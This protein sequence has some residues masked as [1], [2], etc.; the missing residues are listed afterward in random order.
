MNALHMGEQIII[1]II[2]VVTIHSTHSYSI[3]H[4]FVLMSTNMTLLIMKYIDL[5]LNNTLNNAIVSCCQSQLIAYTGFTQIIGQEKCK[6]AGRV[7]KTKL[8]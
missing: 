7:R 3:V 6:W 5:R 1:I 8:M 2:I 4:L